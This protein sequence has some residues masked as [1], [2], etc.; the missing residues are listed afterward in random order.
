MF[1][2][3]L[4]ANEKRKVKNPSKTKKQSDLCGKAPTATVCE[5]K[6]LQRDYEALI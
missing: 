5:S 6:P 4:L 2:F 1:N 3:E